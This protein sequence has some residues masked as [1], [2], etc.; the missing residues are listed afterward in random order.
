MKKLF[1]ASVLILYPLL[2]LAGSHQYQIGSPQLDPDGDLTRVSFPTSV[3]TGAAGAPQVPAWPVRLLLPQGEQAVDVTITYAGRVDLPGVHTLPPIQQ[4]YPMTE[5]VNAVITQPDP[6]IYQLDQFFPNREVLYETTEFLCGHGILLAQAHPVRYN[7]VTGELFYYSEFT[8]NWNGATTREVRSLRERVSNRIE[9]MV[10]NPRELRNYSYLDER[11]D[12][13]DYDYA[14]V[15]APPLAD[16]FQPLVDFKNSLGIVTRMHDIFDILDEYDGADDADRLRNFIINEYEEHGISYL[17]LAGDIEFVPYRSL[18]VSAGGNSDHLP[19]DLFFTG[20]DGSWNND[21]DGR[22]GEAGEE[23][24][25]AEIH[26]GRAS[27][28]NSTEADNFVNK[29]LSYQQTPVI[30]DLESYLMIGENL[31]SVPTWGGDCKDQIVDGSTAHGINTAGIPENIELNYL[32]DRNSYWSISQ[33]FSQLGNGINVT[34]HL[35][36][37]NWNYA[38]KMSNPDVNNGNFTSNGINHNFHIGYS[39]GC[40]PGAFE[41]SDCIV[42]RMTNL[43]NGYACFVANSRYGWYQPGGS[44]ASSQLYDREFFD[45][46]NGEGIHRIGSTNQDAKEDMINWASGD[47]YMRWVHYELN[48]FGDPILS[49]WTSTPLEQDLTYPT[50]LVTGMPQMELTL[51]SAGEPLAGALAA[52]TRNGVLYGR[53]TTDAAGEAVIVFD[54]VII[55]GEYDLM[56]SGN[57]LLPTAWELEVIAPVGPYLTYNSHAILDGDFNSNSQV[58]AGETVDMQ[59]EL[60]NYGTEDATGITAVISTDNPQITIVEA[61]TGFDPIV[62]EGDNVCL[63]PFVFSAD[64]DC[65]DGTLVDFDLTITSNE[66][67]WNSSFQLTVHA[68]LL[69][70]RGLRVVDEANSQ[71]DPGETRDVTITVLN[72]GGGLLTGVTSLL[73]LTDQYVTIDQNSC[74]LAEVAP[75]ETAD[76]CFTMT[77]STDTPVG[78]TVSPAVAINGDLNYTTDFTVSLVVGLTV[79][80]FET[81]DYSGMD[82]VMSG[83]ADWIIDDGNAWE[84]AFCARSGNISDYGQTQISFTGYVVE[85][86]EISF[87]YKVSSEGGYDFLRFYIDGDMQLNLSGNVSWMNQ[88]FPVTVGE[89]TFSWR[90]HKDGGEAD[91][92][93]CGWVDYII[94]PQLGLAPQPLI[95]VDQTGFALEVAN[96]GS[97]EES[98]TISNA[99]EAPLE[100]E[101]AFM[102]AALSYYHDMEAD[103]TG[104]EHA[105][106][107]DDPWHL[108]D[109]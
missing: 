55:P 87:A 45:A 4:Q 9:Q 30:A 98:L 43:E 25:Y 44:G 108:T 75:G 72:E 88:S 29:Q 17:L 22:W 38:M 67:E 19:S 2:L 12:T 97:L 93:D 104:W 86:G 69:A 14:I 58:E 49:I 82:W 80:G 105:A 39:Q 50:V 8:V 32:Y 107:S 33:L 15:T 1:T 10:D 27:V 64:S 70:S 7:P 100:Y 68:P 35:G 62:P 41:Y 34:N 42:E 54:E 24:W 48:L 23:D 85:A 109:H 81:G 83:N 26:V 51:M 92:D 5:G 3:I 16:S 96:G 91:G 28:S 77:A 11:P 99:G 57:N 66:G 56:I 89:H 59:L 47:V 52:L 76:L 78:H 94:F 90:Y 71:L 36:H 18:Y 37:C 31:D 46:L 95:E 74:E 102:D 6:A 65:V 101:L 61:A 103:E 73:T 20:L 106:D 21:N 79:D 53:A 13:E 84:G 63:T 60:H 40:I